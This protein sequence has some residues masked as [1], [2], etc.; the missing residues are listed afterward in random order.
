MKSG[1]LHF[2]KVPNPTAVLLKDKVTQSTLAPAARVLFIWKRQ[3]TK[4]NH[5]GKTSF[6][7]RIRY[8]RASRQNL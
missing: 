6:H 5:H 2:C 4:E 1:N 3:N 8:R 7:I